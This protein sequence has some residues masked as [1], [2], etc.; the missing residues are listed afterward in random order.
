MLL[1]LCFFNPPQYKDK[2]NCK[3]HQMST[4]CKQCHYL[5]A[6]R[7]SNENVPAAMHCTWCV[8]DLC[9]AGYCGYNTILALSMSSYLTHAPW[10]HKANRLLV[11]RMRSIINVIFKI[12]CKISYTEMIDAKGRTLIASHNNNFLNFPFWKMNRKLAGE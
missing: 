4:H 12:P 1:D 11:G 3:N 7:R 10:S 9:A 8:Y 6:I 5:L 2:C